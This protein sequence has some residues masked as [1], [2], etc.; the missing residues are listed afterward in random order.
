MGKSQIFD[1]YA[2]LYD[3]WYD[4][5]PR[6]Y[7][8]EVRVLEQFVPWYGTGLE[9][10]VGTARFAAPLHIEYGI[11][12][13][14]EMA[15]IAAQRD[16]NAVI[17]QGENLPFCDEIF[18]FVLMA[19]VICFIQ[20][21]RKAILE[22]RRVLKQQGT[23][24]MTFIDRESPLGRQ[25]RSDQETSIFFRQ[26][27]FHTL[28]EVRTLLAKANFTCHEVIKTAFEEYGV[29]PSGFTVLRGVKE[30]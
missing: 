3:R 30:P 28:E 9:I 2:E 21:L 5:H 13:S 14:P 7:Q 17:G 16:I 19:T 4:E 10:G 26:A 12:P 8:S 23:L 27:H 20:D 18:D 1:E 15:R 24:I 6:I 25:Y 29:V 22:S 11:D